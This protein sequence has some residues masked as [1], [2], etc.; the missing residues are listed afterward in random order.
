[1]ENELNIFQIPDYKIIYRDTSKEEEILKDFENNAN[2]D[3]GNVTST[4]IY[5]CFTSYCDSNLTSKTVQRR[6][7]MVSFNNTIIGSLVILYLAGA[8]LLTA[9]FSGSEPGLVTLFVGAFGILLGISMLY[10]GILF[11]SIIESSYYN[12]LLS[13]YYISRINEE[14]DGSI[15]NTPYRG[16]Q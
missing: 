10:I 6:Q 16:I 8:R 11:T 15:K 3:Y 4:F 14:V 7:V 5:N 1:M 2:I 12:S 13:D 9:Y